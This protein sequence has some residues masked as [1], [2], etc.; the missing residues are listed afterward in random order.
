MNRDIETLLPGY[1]QKTL[2][3]EEIEAVESWKNK[4]SDNQ[5]MFEQAEKAWSALQVLEE[6]QR[7]DKAKALRKVHRQIS[8]W[9][10]T[11]WLIVWQR[12]AAV[13]MIPL[14]LASVWL[15]LKSEKSGRS[16]NLSVVMH[17]YATPP[18]VKAHFYLPDSSRVWLNSSSTITYPSEFTGDLRH[19]EVSGEA[20]FDIKTNPQKP[21]VVSLGR[22]H[23]RALG[24][25]FNIISYQHEERTE[26]VLQSGKIE[27][28]S[29]NIHAP[30]KLSEM[31]PGEHAL[32]CFHDNSI[33]ISQVETEKH[34]AWIGGRLI[35]K[36]DAMD[37][38]VRKLNRW[39]NVSIE[40][41]NPAIMEYIYTATFEDESIDQILELLTLSAP[42]RY[43]V[44][45]REKQ[46][47]DV[48]TQKKIILRKR[49]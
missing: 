25:R 28:A 9:S 8:L 22:L 21:F 3:N 10:P 43:T 30:H 23:V 36:D 47:Y 32:Y 20:F 46:A 24:T 49:N 7:Y 1:F 35:F 14:L 26:I 33:A 42:I 11:Q 34:V 40:I 18:G 45:P 15:Y 6:M 39:F 31:T 48:Y 37:E 41:D 16:D 38:V 17:T 29:G 27:L 12:A 19:V 44:V 2:T 5:L 13:L 4:E